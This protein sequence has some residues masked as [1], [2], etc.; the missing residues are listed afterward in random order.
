MP[1]ERKGMV[2]NPGA[3]KHVKTEIALCGDSSGWLD[4]VVLFKYM[5]GYCDSGDLVYYLMAI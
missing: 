3:Q 4:T 5:G 2:K 1:E